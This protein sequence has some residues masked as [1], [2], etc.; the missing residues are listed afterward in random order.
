[1]GRQLYFV[2]GANRGI[3]FAITKGLV[4]LGHQVVMGCRTE[5]KALAAMDKISAALGKEHPNAKQLM[6][7]VPLDLEKPETFPIAAKMFETLLGG[8]KVDALIN[9]AG[10]AFTYDAKEPVDVQAA[11]TVSINYSNTAAFTETFLPHVR[12]GGRI[13]FVA[14]RCGLFS[15]MK[16]KEHQE[17]LLSDSLTS[18][19]LRKFVDSYLDATKSGT[20]IEKGFPDTTYGMSKIAINAYTRC[21]ARDP[22]VKAKGILVNSCCP[23]WVK[24]DMTLGEGHKTPDEGADTPIWLATSDSPAALVTGKFFGER[25]EIDLLSEW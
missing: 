10:F 8:R 17:L 9:N 13:V 22:E 11:K 14:S 25:K 5:D 18:N 21:L 1:M 4:G 3:G 23:G 6:E 7:F 20:H 19:N 24:T 16:K 2:T 12:E 15:N